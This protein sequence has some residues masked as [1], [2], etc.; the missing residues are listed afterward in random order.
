MVVAIWFLAATIML[1][2]A[3]IAGRIVALLSE[4]EA[5]LW[6]IKRAVRRY[7]PQ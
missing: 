4:I 6:D 2:G 7:E 3:L 5:H 1:G